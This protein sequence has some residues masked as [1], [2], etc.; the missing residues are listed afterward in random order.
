MLAFKVTTV[1]SSTGIILPKEAQAQ[2]KVKKR[3]HALYDGGAGRRL[4]PDALQSGFRAANG[5]GR[6][7][8]A[9]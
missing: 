8:H 9:R 5:F 7:D 2:L 6:R 4:P 3:R 1:G